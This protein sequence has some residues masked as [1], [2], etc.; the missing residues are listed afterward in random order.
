MSECEYA[1]ATVGRLGKLMRAVFSLPYGL[2]FQLYL[3][4]NLF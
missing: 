2:A 1:A 3:F 4:Y